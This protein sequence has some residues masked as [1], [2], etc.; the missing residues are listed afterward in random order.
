MIRIRGDGLFASGKVSVEDAYAPILER[1]A[2]ALD[3]LPGRIL[4]TGHT[5]SV[6]IRTRRFAS[7]Q[8]LS[9]ER[10]ESV[11]KVLAASIGEPR[12]I[13]TRGRG[14]AE[15]LLP[16][17]PKDAR[18]RRVEITLWRSSNPVGTP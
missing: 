6:P 12:R 11:K 13:S 1:I 8:Q 9:E 7:N 14:A 4:I 2:E 15:L 3:Q 17:A 18:N 5:D 10:A 16:E